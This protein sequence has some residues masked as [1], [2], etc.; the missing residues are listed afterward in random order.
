MSQSRARRGGGRR[1]APE[2]PSAAQPLGCKPSA[3]I[4]QPALPGLGPP[5]HGGRRPLPPFL[6]GGGQPPPLTGRG[7]QAA[8]Q[9]SPRGC[10]LRHGR[11]PPRWASSALAAAS[12]TEPPRRAQVKGLRALIGSPAPPPAQVRPRPQRQVS[13]ALSERGR[14]RRRHPRTAAPRGRS[15]DAIGGRLPSGSARGVGAVASADAAAAFPPQGWNRNPPSEALWG[16]GGGCVCLFYQAMRS[17][18]RGE[19]GFSPQSCPAHPSL[20]EGAAPLN[21]TGP[22][23]RTAL[24]VFLRPFSPPSSRLS[25]FADLCWPSRVKA[26]SGTGE[27]NPPFPGGAAQG[28]GVAKASAPQGSSRACSPAPSAT[29]SNVGHN[30][31]R[32][33]G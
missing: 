29:P 5:A 14:R 23:R 10:R 7:A 30:P 25:G 17:A 20:F 9:Q 22:A 1:T 18:A 24:L 19:G 28:S 12:P 33:L 4:H 27:P 6:P 15:G 2:P 16:G 31:N 26:F 32:E 11:S 3:P 8:P 21:T 13:P